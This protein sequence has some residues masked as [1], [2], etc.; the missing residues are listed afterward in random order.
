MCM[1]KSLSRHILI[2]HSF[3]GQYYDKQILSEMQPYSQ[4]QSFIQFPR[5]TATCFK[6]GERNFFVRSTQTF[7]NT[8]D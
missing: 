4:S 3:T 5:I 2:V 1:C 7:Q 6:I 8:Y